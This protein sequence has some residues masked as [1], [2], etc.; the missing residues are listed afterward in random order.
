MTDTDYKK[1]ELV[2]LY[3]RILDKWTGIYNVDTIREM[4]FF[5]ACAFCLESKQ[6][7]QKT[8]CGSC[9][10]DPLLCCNEGAGGLIGKLRKLCQDDKSEKE[11]HKLV[12]LMIKE[13]ENA[14]TNYSL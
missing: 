8:D 10:I 4:Q 14:I 2:F 1:K 9:K 3:K 7:D 12:S 6:G 13:I 5:H 11:K